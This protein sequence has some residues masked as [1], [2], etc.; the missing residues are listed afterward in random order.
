MAIFTDIKDRKFGFL[1]AAYR[2]DRRPHRISCRCICSK[3]I[4][5][6]VEDLAGG[7]INSCGCQP[8][9]SA[10][11]AQQAERRRQLVR[12]LLFRD[13]MPTVRAGR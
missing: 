6:T 8:A 4:H 11:R 2:D 12:E 3:L 7:I 5:V 1:T 13:A 9:T 10:F